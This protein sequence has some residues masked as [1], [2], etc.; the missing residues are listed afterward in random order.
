MSSL[1]FTF[2]NHSLLTP[3]W[4]IKCPAALWMFS[5][6][7]SLYFSHRLINQQRESEIPLT[8]TALLPT[9]VQGDNPVTLTSD[10]LTHCP[11][12]RVTGSSS[13]E[14]HTILQLDPE[15]HKHI[16]IKNKK[17]MCWHI[18]HTYIC[19][20]SEIHNDP[21]STTHQYGCVRERDMKS[22]SQIQLSGRDPISEAW[23]FEGFCTISYL[24]PRLHSFTS[25]MG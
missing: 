4:E 12:N 5:R 25:N 2:C 1:N 17:F 14:C 15:T 19:S 13:Q 23:E 11:H 20:I 6:V 8:E 21:L 9:T 24:V 22:V 7:L 18:A 10:I 16:F 3:V